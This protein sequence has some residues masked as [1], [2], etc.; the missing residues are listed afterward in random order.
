MRP[1]SS[2][3][4]LLAEFERPEALVAATR[5]AREHGYRKIDAYTPYPVHGLADALD[6]TRTAIPFVVLCGGIAGFFGGYLLQY[7]VSVYAYPLNIGG[8][9]YHSWPSF[10]P[11]TFETTVLLASLSAVLGMLA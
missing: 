6:F 2:S 5:R 9:P 11:V 10:I 8:R 1:K 4:G 3:Y 7:W